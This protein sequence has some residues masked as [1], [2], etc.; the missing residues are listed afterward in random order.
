MQQGAAHTTRLH[1]A[2]DLKY[3]RLYICLTRQCTRSQVLSSLYLLD[4]SMCQ[5]LGIVFFMFLNA[6]DLR[7]CLLY[8]CLT[9]QCARSQVLSSLCLLDSSMCQ[10]SGIVFFM[11]LNAT[12]LRY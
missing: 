6:T 12:D 11:F 1:N 5:I 7:Y 4:S 2:P 9:P 10:I 8:I 3:C